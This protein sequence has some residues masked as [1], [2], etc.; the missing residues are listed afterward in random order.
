MTNFDWKFYINYYTDLK[1]YNLD[2]EE[3]ILNHW[4]HYG[5]Y[6]DRLIRKNLKF[7]WK[8]YINYYDDL[9]TNKLTTKELAYNHW[10]KYGIHEKRVCNDTLLIEDSL[11]EPEKNNLKEVYIPNS[12]ID[13]YYEKYATEARPF[14]EKKNYLDIDLYFYKKGNLIDLN[15]TNDLMSHFNIN[16]NGL[17]YHPKQLLNIYENIEIFKI[18]K[19]IIIKYENDEYLLSNFLN[20]FVYEK[21]FNYFSNLL[22]K[23]IIYKLKSSS[24]LLLV[25]IGDYNIGL[26]LINKIIEYKKLEKFNVSFCFNNNDNCNLLID[27][28]KNNFKYYSVYVS[29]EFGNDIIPTLLMY[30]DIK[31]YNNFKH[32]IKL[33]TKTNIDIF[34]QL[35]DYLLTKK[36]KDLLLGLKQYSNCIN[37]NNFYMRIINDSFNKILIDKYYDI[38]DFNKSFIIGTIFYCKE[39]IFDKILNFMID[40]FQKYLFN[41]MY[42][43][44]CA[45]FNDSYVHF[46]ERLFGVI[47]YEK[48]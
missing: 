33:H 32:I 34:N 31:K 29:N 42:D 38:I 48:I 3:K 47:K 23:N 24:L 4:L 2:N 30:N 37:D 41:N 14:Y 25:F 46:L 40:D 15:N 43:N 45:F 19:D 27:V 39:I 36:L 10:K 12:Y 17:I 1:D 9:A 6:E 35:I 18:N 7:D 5:I 22:I 44:N 11:F 16:H 28:I 26:N 8:F 21:D 13:K 20:K